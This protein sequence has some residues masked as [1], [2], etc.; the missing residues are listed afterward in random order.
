MRGPLYDMSGRPINMTDRVVALVH[1]DPQGV[2]VIAR[3]KFWVALPTEA[4]HVYADK[5]CWL[6]VMMGILLFSAA[7]II[8]GFL[9]AQAAPSPASPLST[10]IGFSRRI[11][12][13]LLTAVGSADALGTVARDLRDKLAPGLAGGPALS[14]SLTLL[15][16]KTQAPPPSSPTLDL[17][18]AQRAEWQEAKALQWSYFPTTDTV[19]LLA[20]IDQTDR[21]IKLLELRPIPPLGPEVTPEDVFPRLD[22]FTGRTA[23]DVRAIARSA[24]AMWEAQVVQMARSTLPQTHQAVLACFI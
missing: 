11:D 8:I 1:E 6:C 14:S 23:A 19:L 10:M 5:G 9:A 18:G 15:L 3:R 24:A 16:N 12:N 20:R 7:F 22:E 13:L 2:D 21:A 4:P 17:I